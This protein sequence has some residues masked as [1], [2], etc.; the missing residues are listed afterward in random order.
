MWSTL[1]FGII[2][3]LSAG[4]SPGPLLAVVITQ[5]LRHGSVEGAKVAVAPLLTDLPIIGMVLLVFNLL[6]DLDFALGLAS[7]AGA[8]F[9]LFLGLQTLRV[10]AEDYTD[11]AESPRSYTQGILVNALSP[12]PYLFWLSVGV[13][14]LIKAA[15]HS[16]GL[17][18]AFLISFFTCLVGAKVMV[19]LL[20]G[21]SREFLSGTF[22]RWLMRTMGLCL[23]G[24]SVLLAKDGVVLTGLY[25]HP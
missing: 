17:S 13:P 8:G 14:T 9:I 4:I 25:T 24:V 23:I 18:I 16:M 6:P 10:Q 1:S 5:S 2:F 3:G 15:Q 7:F 11:S 20:V 22:Y 19:A 21:R 12:H